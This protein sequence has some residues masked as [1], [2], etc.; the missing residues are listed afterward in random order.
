MSR[1]YLVPVAAFSAFAVLVVWLAARSQVGVHSAAWPTAT[2]THAPSSASDAQACPSA[3][4]PGEPVP[5]ALPYDPDGAGY[6]GRPPHPIVVIDR[7]VRRDGAKVSA[8]RIY[9]GGYTGLVGFALP[10]A[11]K[12]TPRHEA[13]SPADGTRDRS[14]VQLV[15]C[16]YV[17]TVAGTGRTCHY[18]P[19]MGPGYTPQP[20]GGGSGDIRQ[21]SARYL[22]VVREA[23]TARTVAGF[24]LSSANARTAND[25][26][27]FDRCPGMVDSS[28]LGTD[29]ILPPLNRGFVRRLRPLVER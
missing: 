6:G 7:A 9:S 29:Q 22:V 28:D 5:A 8:N 11:W 25:P 26:G 4:A 15:A 10:A 12:P 24:H 21:L 27:G 1:R 14:K 17:A 19:Y 13:S 18:W 2:P 3:P 20:G 23:R 16:V